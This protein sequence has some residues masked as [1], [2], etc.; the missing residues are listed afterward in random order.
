MTVYRLHKFK[1][2]L[3]EPGQFWI[4]PCAV[5]AGRVQI[6]R[7]CSIWFGATLR[8]EEEDIAI[9][10]GSNIQDGCVL[11][12]DPSFPLSIGKN[13]TI[14]HRSIVHGCTIGTIR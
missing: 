4:A 5:V 2:V 7:N 3:P 9:G 10:D 14:G 8:A 11:H 13:C 1:P 12:V 6:G